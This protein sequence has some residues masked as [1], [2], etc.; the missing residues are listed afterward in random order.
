MRYL[1]H[2]NILSDAIKPSPSQ[3]LLAWMAEQTDDDLFIASLTLAEIRRGV[4]EKPAGRPRDQLEAWFTGPEGPQALFSG[5]ILPFDERAGLVWARLMV[6]GKSAGRPGSA[7]DT[8]I[9]AVAEAN[10]CV[11]VTDNARHFAGINTI[12]PLRGSV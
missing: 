6:E 10:N 8:I 7:F 9:A 3:S 5:R 12:N 4:M 1:L 2:T 11:V